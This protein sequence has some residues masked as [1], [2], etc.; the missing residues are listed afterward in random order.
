MIDLAGSIRGQRKARGLKQYELARRAEM[1]PGQ[2]CQI[3]NGR[4]SPSFQMVERL[5][6]A[7]DLDVVGLISGGKGRAQRKASVESE[8]PSGLDGYIP[9]RAVEPDA[10]RVL[11]QIEDQEAQFDAQADARGVP[12][13][14]RILLNRVRLSC[15]GAGAAFAEELRTELGLGT[16]PLGD[17]ASALEVRG[18]RLHRVRMAQ[19]T[20]SVAFW[21]SRRA[22]LVIAVNEKV[23]PERERYRLVYELGSAILF[24]SLGKRRLDESLEQHRFL[25]DF[26]AAFLMPGVMVRTYVAATGLGPADWTFASLVEIKRH[27]GVSAEAFALRLEELGLISATLRLELRDRLRAYYKAHPKAMEP[28]VKSFSSRLDSVRNDGGDRLSCMKVR[29][30]SG[31]KV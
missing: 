21:N 9:L 5:A 24:V 27:F 17:F 14:C 1:S 30:K 8:K 13:E 4:V 29:N 10:L 3:E 11:R 31:V 15:A 18:V 7:L 26:T 22:T 23:T 20:P 28:Q 25:T 16:A 6:A 12:S 19:S 2:L